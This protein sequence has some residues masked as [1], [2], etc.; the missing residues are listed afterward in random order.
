MRAAE[1]AADGLLPAGRAGARGAAAGDRGAPA[2]RGGQRRGVH[3][4]SLDWRGADRAGLRERRAGGG[5][6][7]RSWPSA[8]ER[9]WRF[10]RSPT[11][12]RA[13]AAAIDTLGKLAWAGA[14]DS[15][16]DGPGG[17][18]PAPGAVAARGGRA[19]GAARARGRRQGTQ[20]ALPLDLHDAPELRRAGRLGAAA[21]RL[22]LDRRHAARAPARADA[23]RPAR[24]TR[25]PA[26]TWSARATG[27]RCGWRGSWWPASGRPPRR[28]SRSC[29]SRTSTA[30]ST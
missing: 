27:R 9:R 16:V 30:R 14:C 6:R 11:S 3:G 2:V 21:G 15:L 8:S 20:L 4:S 7:R 25:S 23:A 29:C 22:R 24:G 28:G 18:P 26:P 1:R 19:G 10:G 17:G 12:P 5:G 13:R